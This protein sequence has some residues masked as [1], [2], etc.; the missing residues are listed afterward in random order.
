MQEKVFSQGE[1]I[2]QQGDL[3]DSFF[4]IVNGAVEVIA[5][6][7]D[8]EKKLTELKEGDF[9]GETASGSLPPSGSQRRR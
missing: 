6:Q 9:F 5:K 3:G 2:I 1:V 4:Q 7:G 8:E